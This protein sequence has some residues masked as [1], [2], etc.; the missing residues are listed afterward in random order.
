MQIDVAGAPAPPFAAI[1][2][3]GVVAAAAVDTPSA[4]VGDA[5]DLFD[6]DVDHVAGPA[7]WQSVLVRVCSHRMDRGTCVGSTRGGPG[8]G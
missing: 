8:A 7:G 4:A 3:L 1:D 6:V 5:A 2:R